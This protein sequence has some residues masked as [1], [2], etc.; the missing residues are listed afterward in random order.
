MNKLSI[1]LIIYIEILFFLS[2]KKI[3]EYIYQKNIDNY[4][5]F[6]IIKTWQNLK[7]FFISLVN[8]KN[9]N[10]KGGCVGENMS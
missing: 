10:G 3:N 6:F 4:I 1:N 8:L 7:R 5:I 2:N 9:F